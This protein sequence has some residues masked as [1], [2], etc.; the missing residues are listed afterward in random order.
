MSSPKE[1]K[2]G[3]VVLGI[4]GDGTRTVA[5]AVDRNGNEVQ[6]AEF[7]PANLRLLRDD[8]LTK[9]FKGIAAKMPQ[10][11]AIAI[12]MAGARTE[13]DRNRIRG[14][15]AKAWPKIPCTATNDLE[16]A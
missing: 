2:G 4:E 15:A 13:E 9:H 14:A 11:S 10:P 16:T 1:S 8:Q 5:T 12:G 6:R 7:G 3:A